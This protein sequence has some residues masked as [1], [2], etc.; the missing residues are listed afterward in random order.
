[1]PVKP[2][3]TGVHVSPD[4]GAIDDIGF[5]QAAQVHGG[6]PRIGRP[7]A[8]SFHLAGHEVGHLGPHR[9]WAALVELLADARP[10]AFGDGHS[11]HR[12]RLGRECELQEP[13]AE[14]LQRP[15]KVARRRQ[16][17]EH[18]MGMVE[19][20][21]EHHRQKE[22]LL[23]REISVER[24]LG[25][26]DALGDRRHAG[27]GQ[28]VFAEH[29]P[30]RRQDRAALGVGLHAHAKLLCRSPFR[31]PTVLFSLD[32]RQSGSV[33]HLAGPLAGR[34]LCWRDLFSRRSPW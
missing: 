20:L 30:G 13:R 22:L 29:R 10:G 26:A 21:I 6:D 8:P 31:N 18:L 9:F 17:V 12:Q 33:P 1:V 2:G 27:A 11:A 23:G 5:Q 15:A 34:G 28:A 14:S 24:R 4:Q 19:D 25:A 16:G 32:M 7:Q 3:W